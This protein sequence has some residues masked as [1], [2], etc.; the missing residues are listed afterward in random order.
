MNRNT[1]TPALSP[2]TQKSQYHKIRMAR[3]KAQVDAAIASANQT[4]SLLLVITGNGKGKSTSGFGMVARALGHGLK[5]GVCQFIKSRTD[6][7]EE[8]FFK[9]HPNCD[10]H[11][12]GDGFTWDT[13]N[14]DQHRHLRTRLGDRTANAARCLV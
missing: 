10:W 2:D 6:T 9:D 4:K 12:L 11:V 14:R 7:G 5:V 13:Q 1:E 3:K 8:A